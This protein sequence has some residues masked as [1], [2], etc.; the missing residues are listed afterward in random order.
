[1]ATNDLRSFGKRIQMVSKEINPNVEQL[2]KKVAVAV[3]QTV[4]MATPVDTGR[5]RSNW[6]V[7]LNQEPEGVRE[8][9]VEGKEGSTGG[10]NAQAAI[11]EARREISKY[12]RGQEINI[13]NNLPYIERL[14]NGHSAQA[15]AGFVQKAIHAGLAVIKSISLIGGGRIQ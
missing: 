6:Q 7:G 3:D 11:D 9:Y 13:T 14:N 15:P 5:A 8:P 12:K 1:M 10:P 2:M 4:V